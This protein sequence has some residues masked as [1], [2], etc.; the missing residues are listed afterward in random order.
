MPSYS[1]YHITHSDDT[2]CSFTAIIIKNNIQ[3]HELDNF[4]SDFLAVIVKIENWSDSVI[5]SSLYALQNIKLLA[6][7]LRL[8][9][10]L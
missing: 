4:R 10:K 1:I 3:H 6:N 2:T 8:S 7:N 9:L 5:I